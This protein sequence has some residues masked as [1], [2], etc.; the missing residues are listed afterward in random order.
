MEDEIRYYV[1]MEYLAGGN[2]FECLNKFTEKQAAKIL[3]QVMLA[4]NYMHL[5]K[6]THRDLKL[7]NIMCMEKDSANTWVKLTDFGFATYFDPLKKMDLTLGTQLY[8]APELIK[9]EEY[10]ERVDVWAFGVIAYILITGEET[11]KWELS[12]L[13]FPTAKWMNVS[14]LCIDF[15]TQCLQ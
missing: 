14:E 11:N 1:V 8:M 7:E 2:L 9:Y 3:N 15:V 12:P 13:K 10:D 6:M 5:Q 4:L